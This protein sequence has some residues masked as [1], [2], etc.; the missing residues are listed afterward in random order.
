[1]EPKNPENNRNLEEE[2]RV[3]DSMTSPEGNNGSSTIK[4][5]ERPNFIV[6]KELLIIFLVLELME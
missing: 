4:H 6:K 5:P 2:S 1:M 3:E